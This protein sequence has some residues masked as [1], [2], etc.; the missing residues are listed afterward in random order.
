MMAVVFADTGYWIALLNPQ[1]QLHDYACNLSIQLESSHIVTS[2]MVLAKVLNDFSKRGEYLR[3]LALQL[4]ETLCTDSNVTIIPQSDEQFQKGIALYKKRPD[5]QWS[6]TDCVSFCIM[7]EMQIDQA[8]S[9]D[10]HFE[11]A[12]FSALLRT[13]I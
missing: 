10:K 5:K 3:Q 13:L 4:I 1:D 12:G 8:L 9:H 2:Q 7:R 11:Q 6:L